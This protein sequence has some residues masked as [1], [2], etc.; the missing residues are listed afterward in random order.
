MHSVEEFLAEL[1]TGCHMDEVVVFPGGVEALGQETALDPRIRRAVGLPCPDVDTDTSARANAD[2]DA[3]GKRGD[4]PE[5]EGAGEGCVGEAGSAPVAT[6]AYE[7][8]DRLSK[9][10]MLDDVKGKIG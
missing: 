7:V 3:A 4:Q 2:A 10:G 8:L 1:H 5:S 6:T 9:E